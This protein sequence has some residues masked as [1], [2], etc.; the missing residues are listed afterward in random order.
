V[1][2]IRRLIAENPD[3]SRRALSVK[4]CKSLNWVQ[5]N[6]AFK[7]MVCRRYMLALDRAGYI[8]LPEKKCSPPNPFV[9][10]KKPEQIGIDHSPISTGLK[11]IRPLNLRQVR[12]STI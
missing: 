10:R 5:P 3:D 2:L 6:G 4:L 11:N 9:D 8:R 1:A 7:E 12:R